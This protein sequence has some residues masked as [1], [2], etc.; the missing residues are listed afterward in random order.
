LREKLSELQRDVK[1]GKVEQN[2]FTQQ[3]VEILS[4]LKKLGENLS[5][6]E[7]KFLDQNITQELKYFVA[8]DDKEVG[9]RDTL[10]NQVNSQI[11]MAEK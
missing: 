5:E 2:I 11:K 9:K 4:A 8:V 1:L 6:M 3:T 10:M 7:K